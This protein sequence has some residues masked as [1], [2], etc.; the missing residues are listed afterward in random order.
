MLC[1]NS[2]RGDRPVAS[3]LLCVCYFVCVF[4]VYSPLPHIQIIFFLLF[5]Y[6]NI[7]SRVVKQSNV[8]REPHLVVLC[9]AIFRLLCLLGNIMFIVFIVHNRVYLVVCLCRGMGRLFLLIVLV[10]RSFALCRYHLR[11][12]IFFCGYYLRCAQYVYMWCMDVMFDIC[13]FIMVVLCCVS[14][15]AQ[16]VGVII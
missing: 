16:W 14:L 1:N 4:L 15:F 11:C 6:N 5:F 13:S 7:K 2:S 12:L 8:A 10:E 9:R 3:I